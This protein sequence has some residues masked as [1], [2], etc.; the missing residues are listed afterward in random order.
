MENFFKIE[1]S[2]SPTMH[3]EHRNLSNRK[4][5]MWGSVIALCLILPAAALLYTQATAERHADNNAGT[6]Q[7]SQASEFIAARPPSQ[8]VSP[9]HA[10][11][12][13]GLSKEQWAKTRKEMMAKEQWANGDHN[14]GDEGNNY[15]VCETVG[16]ENALRFC[17][18]REKDRVREEDT[19]D[20]YK[21]TQ[22]C[23]HRNGKCGYNIATESDCAGEYN[24]LYAKWLGTWDGH[25]I[26]CLSWKFDRQG[27]AKLAKHLTTDV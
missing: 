7:W 16:R 13:S 27:R 6:S 2:V 4:R 23:T 22:C 17:R 15:R 10:Y 8:A 21:E 14:T 18:I 11:V 12:P 9:L 5:W 25:G 20:I 19:W 26:C 24:S 1:D 3:D